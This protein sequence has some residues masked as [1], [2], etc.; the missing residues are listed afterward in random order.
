MSMVAFGPSLGLPVG[1]VAT[2]MSH[3]AACWQ[4]TGMGSVRWSF[5]VECWKPTGLLLD[6]AE[7]LYVYR[8]CEAC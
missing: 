2:Y 3:G 8:S 1:N 4:P 6:R 5:G 7:G